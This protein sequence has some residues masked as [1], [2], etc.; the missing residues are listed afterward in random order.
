MGL[1]RRWRRLLVHSL[2]AVCLLCARQAAAQE[3]PEA[4]IIRIGGVIT[5]AYSEA[6]QRKITY[7][8]EQGV[9]T[10]ILELD[11]PGG[12][13]EDSTALADFVFQQDELRV[14]AYVHS[15]AYSGGT[16]VALAC[17]EIYIDAAVGRMGDVA[18]VLPT[19]EILGEKIQS[20]VRETMLGYGRARG[21]PE[22]LVKAM[23]TKEIEVYRL[24]MQDEPEGHY[25]YVTSD[26]LR[27][28][29]EEKL[30]KIIQKDLIVPAGELL[31]MHADKAVEYGFARKAVRS[32]QE[33]M[34]VL[35]LNP[36]RVERLYLT[37][38]ERLLTFLDMFSPFLIV[39]GFI[40]LF[41]ELSHPGFGLPGILGIACFVVFFLVKYTL[42][43]A[44]MLEVVLFLIGLVLLALEIF[45]IPG[46]GVVGITGIALL[47]ISL[48]L[49][50]Q[51]FVIP[52]TSGETLAFQWNLLKVMG[53]FAA[54]G[55][56]LIVLARFLS[57]VPGLGAIM[58]RADLAAAR[59]AEIGEMHMPGLS[60]MAGREG[61]ALTPLHPAGRAEFGERI[62]DV[63]TEGDFID[64][65]A[66]IRIREVRGN[67]V[68]VEPQREA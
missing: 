61:I 51:E 45:V 60:S 36:R 59:V 14:V 4:F 65:G 13:I 30:D 35:Q 22:A 44:R 24:Q 16:M 12:T 5:Q 41:I 50:C 49:A 62:L 15:Q 32:P 46:F 28:W 68:V 11:T 37:G 48:V 33:L 3:K 57:S 20:V 6:V 27:A 47:F 1:E 52:Q 54:T 8:L 63:V 7:A 55:V 9:D 21:Y 39:G 43:Y 40:L 29:T 31:T 25:I 10:V 26:D 64:K 38:S 66:R 34:D 18:P 56:S 53:S 58:H 2:G 17:D 67:T 19:G 23:V 42:H